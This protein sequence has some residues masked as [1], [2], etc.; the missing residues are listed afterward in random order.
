MNYSYSRISLFKH[1]KCN[2][3]GLNQIYRMNNFLIFKYLYIPTTQ[4]INNSI[5]SLRVV[6]Q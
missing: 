2:S 3:T 1:K 5:F 6:V 4:I